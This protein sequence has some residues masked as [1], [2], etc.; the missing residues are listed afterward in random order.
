MNGNPS[1]EQKRYHDNLRQM[2]YEQFAGRG[3]LHHIF[4]SKWK[5]KGFKKPGEWLVI[6]L[7]PELHSNIKSFTFEDE[8][9][10]FLLQ[11]RQYKNAWGCESPVP[12]NLIESYVLMR[13]RQDITRGNGFV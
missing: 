3:E 10:A 11:Q 7:P 5:R 1:A 6:L 13:H 9:E 8:R 4:G 12:A 2:L